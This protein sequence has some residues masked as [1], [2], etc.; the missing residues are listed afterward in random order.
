M[1]FMNY[2]TLVLNLSI[3]YIYIYIHLHIHALSQIGFSPASFSPAFFSRVVETANGGPFEEIYWVQ[4]A[5][6]T[7][8]FCHCD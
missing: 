4:G 5:T 1:A 2:I 3:M 7:V 8:I 6:K